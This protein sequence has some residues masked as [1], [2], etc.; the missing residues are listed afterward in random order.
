MAGT[1]ATGFEPRGLATAAKLWKWAGFLIG[2]K[3]AILTGT[4]L[5]RDG[6]LGVPNTLSG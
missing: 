6:G 2:K 3:G 1:V 5:A 4:P